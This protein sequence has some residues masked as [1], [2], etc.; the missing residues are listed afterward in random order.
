MGYKWLGMRYITNKQELMRYNG[1]YNGNQRDYRNGIIV[2]VKP[3]MEN[4]TW[5]S[6]MVNYGDGR[7]MLYG[8]RCHDRFSMAMCCFK[9]N[10]GLPMICFVPHSCLV[11]LHYTQCQRH[12]CPL[13][14]QRASNSRDPD[15]VANPVNLLLFWGPFFTHMF[16]I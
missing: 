10:N 4:Q 6:Q 14:V 11:A 12:S 8:F 1:I 9:S 2:W 15:N 5:Q 3:G 16:G 7:G 13:I